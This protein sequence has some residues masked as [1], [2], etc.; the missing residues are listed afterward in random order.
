MEP[1][2][3]AP[4]GGSPAFVKSAEQELKQ[5]FGHDLEL[6][7]P[8]HPVFTIAADCATVRY[9]EKAKKLL[10]ADLNKP[11][12]KKN[13]ETQPKHPGKKNRLWKKNLL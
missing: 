4:A 5:A 13:G 9:R 11:L 3:S 2:A 10:G 1:A 12:L 7:P 8:N 6:V